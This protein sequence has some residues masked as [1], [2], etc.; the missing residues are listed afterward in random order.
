MSTAPS[1]SCPV[2]GARFGASRSTCPLD[3]VALVDAAPSSAPELPG[4]R[5]RRELGRG[6]LCVV[7]EA[8]REDGELVAV[9]V[10][11]AQRARV[12]VLRERFLREGRTAAALTHPGIV[13][14]LDVREAG[15]LAVLVLELAAGPTIASLLGAG[16]LEPSRALGLAADLAQTLA[17][18]HARGVVHRDVKPANVV[19]EPRDP[20]ERE[21]WAGLDERARLLDFGLAYVRDEEALTRTGELLGSPAYMAPELI[22]LVEGDTRAPA[23]DA[24]A[25]GCVLFEMLAGRPPFT[26]RVPD[27][28]EAHVTSPPPR[29]SEHAPLPSSV[30]REID[31]IVAATLA[32]DPAARRCPSPALALELLE[33]RASLRPDRAVRPDEPS[34]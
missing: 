20:S 18:V 12:P 10:L 2:C 31:A 3:R 34:S 24:Y 17:F 14:V 26:G 9:K 7:Y 29:V 13:R 6:G 8:A 30:A 25:L 19:V 4:L 27:V 11:S 22:E 23:V 21:P 28:L 32:K 15:E 33:L 5:V 1:K 16:P